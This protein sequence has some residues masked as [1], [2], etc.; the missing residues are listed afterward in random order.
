MDQLL[1]SS[2][3]ICVVVIV[4]GLIVVVIVVMNKIIS[5]IFKTYVVSVYIATIDKPNKYFVGAVIH[6]G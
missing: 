3:W 2:L 4:I 1:L 5:M 6:H